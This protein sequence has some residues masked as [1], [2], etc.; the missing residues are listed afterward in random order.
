[1]FSFFVLF[2]GKIGAPGLEEVTWLLL[3]FVGGDWEG[4]SAVAGWAQGGELGRVGLSEASVKGQQL[5][6][7]WGQEGKD[8]FMSS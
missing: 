5:K 7:M 1:M 4:S 2:W 3:G 6:E 8:S